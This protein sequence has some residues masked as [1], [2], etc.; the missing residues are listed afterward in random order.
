MNV[1]PAPAL[2]VIETVDHQGLG[3]SGSPEILAM[4]PMTPTAQLVVFTGTMI[5][6]IEFEIQYMSIQ[7]Q[8]KSRKAV[9][10]VSK[11]GNL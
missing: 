6:M 2:N 11:I 9:A 7:C 3:C 8:L 5:H 10:E 1:D 4:K